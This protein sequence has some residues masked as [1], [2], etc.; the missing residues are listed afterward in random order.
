MSETPL[1]VP[2]ADRAAASQV[3]AFM[4]EVN[5][6]HGTRLT[7]Y[8]ELH[9]W[10]VAHPDLFW[11]LVWDVCGVIG[12]KGERLVADAGQM[13]GAR[14][15]PDA[16]AQFRGEPVAPVGRRRG[17][18]VPRRGQGQRRMSWA[19]LDRAACRACS[20]RWRRPASASATAS[21]RCC[22]TGPRRSRWCWR[23]PRSARSGRPARPISA[24]AA[25]STVSARSSRRFSSRST[26]TGTTASRSGC[27]TSSSPLSTQLPSAGTV[28]IVDYLGEAD[29][30]AK[31]LP[32][33]VTLDA[34]LKP[35]AP[36]PLA[37]ERLPFD[38]P[39]YILFSSGTTGVPKC[40]VHGAGGTL[41]QHLKEHRLQCDLRPGERLFYFTTL[42]WMM[43][44]WLVSGLATRGDADALRRL[45]VRADAGVAVGLRAGRAHQR[46]RNLGEIYRR[47]RQGWARAGAHA[48][49][50]GAADDRLDRLAARAGKL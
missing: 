46:V 32:R 26:A 8:R 7:D 17:A 44:N 3:A 33:A 4:A 34:F 5:R 16:T 1:W 25:C 20:R 47:L 15:L 45:A 37:F 50:A 43:W 35:H 49:S 39:I 9:A 38:H 31:A 42:G 6:R 22:R 41:L 40:I 19:E 2:S 30:V 48:R 10:T 14:F 36:R 28:V 21:R 11:S 29:A 13:P 12:D 24:S 27:S 18:H 23:P